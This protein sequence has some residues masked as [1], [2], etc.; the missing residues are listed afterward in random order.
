[1][2]TA[3]YDTFDSKKSAEFNLKRIE[4]YYI[5]LNCQNSFRGNRKQVSS[6]KTCFK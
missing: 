3:Y 5:F 4:R 2:H 6:D 1:M